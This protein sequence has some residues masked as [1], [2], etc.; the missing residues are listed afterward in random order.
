MPAQRLTKHFVRR[1]EHRGSDVRLDVGVLY[2]PVA[3]PRIAIR[4]DKWL[5]QT[6][7]AIPF[8]YEDHININVLELRMYLHTLLWRSRARAFHSS[9]F[10]HLLDSQVCIAVATKGRSS[11]RKL[12]Q[13]LRRIAALVVTMHVCPLLGYVATEDNPADM[14]SRLF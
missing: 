13:L 4:A 7:Q 12:N 11:S 6:V 14:P 5:W 2:R 10:V 1:V 3:W 8:Q 9:R